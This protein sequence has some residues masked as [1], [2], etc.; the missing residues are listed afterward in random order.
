MDYS[1]WAKQGFGTADA[2]IIANNTIEVID[3]K[4]GKGVKVDAQNNPQLM[5]YGLGAFRGIRLVI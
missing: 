2:L 1:R 3:L 4:Y 5:L